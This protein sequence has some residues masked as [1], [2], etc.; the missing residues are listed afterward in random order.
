MKKFLLSVGLSISICLGVLF[1][2]LPVSATLN[3]FDPGNI[4]DDTVATN[5][6]SMNA[7]QIQAF[8]TAK[9]PNA[10]LT[11]P[12]RQESSGDPTLAVLSMLLCAAGTV[13]H[14]P[15][16]VITDRE[17]EGVPLN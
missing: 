11:D 6:G 5:Y 12:S 10:T 3:D 16:Y 14:I 7:Q 4:M 1:T 8:S 2:S 13:H 17:M 9:F 15:V